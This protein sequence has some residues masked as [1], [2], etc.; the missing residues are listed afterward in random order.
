[1]QDLLTLLGAHFAPDTKLPELVGC[2]PVAFAEPVSGAD[3][4]VEVEA[5]MSYEAHAPSWA[6]MNMAAHSFSTSSGTCSGSPHGPKQG[7]R[8]FPTSRR[9]TKMPIFSK[10][11]RSIGTN[12]LDAGGLHWIVL[13]VQYLSGCCLVAVQYVPGSCPFAI[14][15]GNLCNLAGPGCAASYLPHI[16]SKNYGGNMFIIFKLYFALEI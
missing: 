2:A 13:D 10:T 7:T 8:H 11:F 9:L 3:P 6:S 1:M 16:F 15:R 14:N 12:L 5:Q 4:G